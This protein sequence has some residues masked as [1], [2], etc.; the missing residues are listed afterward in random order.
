[1]I[2]DGNRKK[3]GKKQQEKAIGKRKEKETGKMSFIVVPFYI[4]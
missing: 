1:M 3:A 2:L 4:T